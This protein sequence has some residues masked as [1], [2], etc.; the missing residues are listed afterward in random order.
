MIA[1]LEKTF[2][3]VEEA[4]KKLQ[5]SKNYTRQLL[6]E[7][8]SKDEI[9]LYGRKMFFDK[10]AVERVFEDKIKWFGKENHEK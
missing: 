10:K 3:E 9:F 5:F 4:S 2:L 1:Y 7:K 8:L 6:K